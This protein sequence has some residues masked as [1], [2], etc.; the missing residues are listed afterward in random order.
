[1]DELPQRPIP[2]RGEVTLK[3]N[4]SLPDGGTKNTRLAIDYAGAAS[5]RVVVPLELHGRRPNLPFARFRETGI[6][7]PITDRSQPVV[8]RLAI[9]TVE[10]AGE[11]PW[12]VG[13]RPQA[14]WLTAALLGESE[15]QSGDSG[16]VIRKYH[17][18]ITAKLS[19]AAGDNESAEIEFE[20]APGVMKRPANLRVVSTLIPVVKA[21]PARLTVPRNLADSEIIERKFAIIAAGAG[22]WDVAV[23]DVLLA[24]IEVERLSTESGIEQTVVVFRAAIAPA[25]LADESPVPPIRIAVRGSSDH[26]IEVPVML[27]D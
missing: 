3:V 21:I 16:Q 22:P 9:E 11:P 17:L 10:Q 15:V 24:A 19:A 27:G 20:T 7:L 25:Q 12:I 18:E 4:V 6:S 8:R 2:V 1:V 14:G 26:T 23:E 13:L 5:G